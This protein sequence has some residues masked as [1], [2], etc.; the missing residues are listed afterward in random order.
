MIY[1]K[2]VVPG[3]DDVYVR[4]TDAKRKIHEAPPPFPTFLD[5]PT[6]SLA[7]EMYADKYV[8]MPHEASLDF[9]GTGDAEKK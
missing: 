6:T 8:H 9:P 4:V 1:V 2:G 5:D 7:E 3:H